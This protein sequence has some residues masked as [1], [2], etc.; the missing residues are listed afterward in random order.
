[1]PQEEMSMSPEEGYGGGCGFGGSTTAQRSV[2]LELADV[3]VDGIFWRGG[4]PAEQK[5]WTW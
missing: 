4:R 2:G 3:D 5:H 1:V